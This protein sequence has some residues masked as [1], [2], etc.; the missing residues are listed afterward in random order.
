[1]L[2]F[3]SKTHILSGRK[4]IRICQLLP[5]SKESISGPL[6]AGGSLAVEAALV[7]PLFLFFMLTL[8][9]TL[10]LLAFSIRL[11]QILF[12]EGIGI[13]EKVY[14]S[15]ATDLSKAVSRMRGK[16]RSADQ[17]PV[18]GGADGLDFSG[19]DLT[20]TEFAD[21]SVQYTAKLMFNPFRLFHREFC[22]HV[23]FHRW[24][25][26][27]NGLHGRNA[28]G[29][30]IYVYITE[31]SQVYHRSRNCTHIRLH[32]SEADGADI[33]SLCNTDG[34]RYKPCRHCHPKKGDAPLY[35]TTDGDCYHN[36][37]TCSGLSRSVRAI[38]LSQVGNRRPCSRC[39]Y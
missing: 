37:L 26:Y 17:I 16:L 35:I 27:E 38:P 11:Q 2:S 4:R 33:D 7:V 12:E 20:D 18:E 1:M 36:T 24:I 15:D 34:D 32:I 23:L 28:A 9:S 39:G 19:S 8:L 13:S 10:H 5:T 21:L 3:E 29:T 6:V 25:G 22:Q 31:D 14:E 30:E